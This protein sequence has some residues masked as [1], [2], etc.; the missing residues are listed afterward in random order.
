[1]RKTIIPLLFFLLLVPALATAAPPR[2]GAY[3]SGFI[4]ASIPTGTNADSV[5]FVSGNSFN[6]RVKFDP[7]IYLGATGGYDFGMLRLEGE[8]SY[9]NSDI[10]SITDKSD[11]FS[12]R[13]VDGDIEAIAFMANGFV[14]FHNTSRVTPY[15]GGGIGFAS[16]RLSDTT[17]VDTRGGQVGSFP[18]YGAADDTVFAWQAGAGVEIALNR[19]VSLDLGYRYFATEKADFES[20]LDINT[21]MKYES[22]NATVGVRFK[23]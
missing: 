4:G 6:D 13:N 21:S 16:L 10:K 1:M 23:F 7:G 18:V 2:P 9:R 12:L 14:D 5:D 15:I 3:V 20:D 22:H 11:G 8:I 17:A 19:Q